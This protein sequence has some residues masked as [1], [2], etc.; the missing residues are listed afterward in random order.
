MKKVRLT[1]VNAGTYDACDRRF[2]IDFEPAKWRVTDN[3]R[4][5]IDPNDPSAVGRDVHVEREF[6]TLAEVRRWIEAQGC[7]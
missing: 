6:S 1:R 3:Q 7:E 4:M 2:F 5:E